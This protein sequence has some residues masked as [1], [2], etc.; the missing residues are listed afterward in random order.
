MVINVYV[1]LILKVLTNETFIISVLESETIL[2][3]LT[4]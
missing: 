1:T 3:S 4:K 2:E